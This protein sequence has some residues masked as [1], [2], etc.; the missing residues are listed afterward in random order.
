V[1]GIRAG[2]LPLARFLAADAAPFDP[3]HPDRVAGFDVPPDPKSTTETPYG[4]GGRPP[5]Q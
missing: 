2:N 5:G 1:E 4:A 3:S